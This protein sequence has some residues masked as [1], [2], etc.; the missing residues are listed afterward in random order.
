MKLVKSIA[1]FAVLAFGPPAAHALSEDLKFSLSS[2]GDMNVTRV[3]VYRSPQDTNPRSRWKADL[4]RIVLE[5]KVKFGPSVEL[6]AEVEFEHGG[7]GST[8]E[9]DGLEESGEFESEVEAGGEVVVERFEARIRD[10]GGVNV[11]F[12]YIFVPVGLIV[13]RHRP[14][15][16]FTTRRNR[17][18]DRIL[19]NAWAEMGIAAFGSFDWV[20]YEA[21]VYG[22]L[23]SEFFR[24]SSWIKGGQRRLFEDSFVDDLA[25][26]ARLDFG[27]PRTAIAGFSLY[28][29]NSAGNRR[30]PDKL[31]DDATVFLW[32]LHGFYESPTWM[33][34]GLY[35]RGTLNNADKVS[36]ANATLNGP[37]RPS[38][39]QPQLGS[40]AEAYFLEVG[41]NVQD[42]LSLERRLD[43]FARFDA[44]DPMKRVTENIVRDERFRESGWTA[45]LNWYARPQAILKAQYGEYVTGKS[46]LPADRQISFGFGYYF[47]TEG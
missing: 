19:P 35:L 8:L 13:K 12:G 25:L 24:K 44:V 30:N 43:F 9:F 3:D 41:R 47:S 26:A 1:I 46:E 36:A 29:G 37:A 40:E 7:T 4:E 33:A 16:Y 23:N 5:P 45:G 20:H 6:L 14:D 15:Q 22:A 10:E 31:A 34:R 27:R 2:Y 42:L 38:T 18:E 39:G 17:A 21:G 32:D 11:R 28:R